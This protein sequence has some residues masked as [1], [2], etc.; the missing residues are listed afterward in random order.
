MIKKISVEVGPIVV[1]FYIDDRFMR[2]PFVEAA[3]ALG[4]LGPV[5]KA[6]PPPRARGKK[7]RR[8]RAAVERR[9]RRPAGKRRRDVI[10]MIPHKTKNGIVYEPKIDEVERGE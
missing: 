3:G 7:A 5:S 9:R 2:D 8:R 10:D 4:F 6:G 1:E